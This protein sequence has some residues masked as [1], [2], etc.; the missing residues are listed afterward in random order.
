MPVLAEAA[1]SDVERR[2]LGGALTALRDRL[3]DDLVA[4]WLYGSRA[5]GS[6]TRSPTSTCWS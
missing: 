2:A 5:R 3:G 6:P 1:L 4:V